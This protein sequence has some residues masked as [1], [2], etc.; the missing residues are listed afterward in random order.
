MAGFFPFLGRAYALWQGARERHV[1]LVE[2]LGFWGIHRFHAI[3]VTKL[4]VV[5]ALRKIIIYKDH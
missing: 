4:S 5:I 3:I 1:T 2:F